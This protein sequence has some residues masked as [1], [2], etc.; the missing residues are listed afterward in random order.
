MEQGVRDSD[1]SQS[2]QRPKNSKTPEQGAAG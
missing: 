2:A 1:Y